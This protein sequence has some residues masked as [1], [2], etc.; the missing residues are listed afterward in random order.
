MDHDCFLIPHNSDN[1][2]VHAMGI[3]LHIAYNS[4]CK[5]MYSFMHILG[6][7]LCSKGVMFSGKRFSENRGFCALS[8]LDVNV[9][10]VELVSQK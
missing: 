7:Y 4:Y 3:A 2:K 5:H 1:I 10:W 9:F 6:Y 8:P